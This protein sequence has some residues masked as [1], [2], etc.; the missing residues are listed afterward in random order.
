[1]DGYLAW[2]DETPLD[3]IPPGEDVSDLGALGETRF[4]AFSREEIIRRIAFARGRGRS[5]HDIATYLG[6]TEE[7]ALRLYD[8]Q[9]QEDSPA[10]AMRA[11][12]T[13]IS[14]QVK[15]IFRALRD[16]IIHAVRELAA[17]MHRER[18]RL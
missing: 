15:V 5:W 12:A 9:G 13:V 8:G 6:I 2:L 3:Q 14:D 17:E 16:A 4:T 7:D 18:T 1:M 10:A 11:A